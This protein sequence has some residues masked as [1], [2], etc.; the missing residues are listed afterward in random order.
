[1]TLMNSTRI[2]SGTFLVVLLGL[3][4]AGCATSQ[5]GPRCAEDGEACSTEADCCPN[6]PAAMRTFARQPAAKARARVKAKGGQSE[7]FGTLRI[8]CPKGH[9]E[10]IAA[11]L[12]DLAEHFEDGDSLAEA[13]L[14]VGGRCIE[15][16]A[17]TDDAVTC[18]LCQGA[19]VLQVWGE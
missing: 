3:C 15:G 14:G 5:P 11:L 7:I 17:D 6:C 12:D 10:Q 2:T 16:A 4:V 8:M 13:R 19:A 18:A 1:M 9:D